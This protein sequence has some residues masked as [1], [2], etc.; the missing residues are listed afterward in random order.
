M[1]TRVIRA[2][3]DLGLISL[4]GVMTPT[5]AF[6]A[7]EAGAH[8]LKLFPAEIV[9]PAALKALRAI[10]PPKTLLLPVGG[11]G[12]DNLAAY[13]NAGADGF[14]LGSSLYKPGKTLYDIKLDAIKFIA[15]NAYF[16]ALG[17]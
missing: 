14:G 3:L 13:R 17:D 10:L 8:G 1:R 16:K 2:A 4:P 9:S 5:E 12:L 15:A 7:L 11:I 6:T